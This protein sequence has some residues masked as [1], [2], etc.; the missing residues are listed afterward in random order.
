MENKLRF[1]RCKFIASLPV[2]MKKVITLQSN[3]FKLWKIN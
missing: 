1:Y 3:T 2:D